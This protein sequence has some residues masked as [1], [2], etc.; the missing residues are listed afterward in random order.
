MTRSLLWTAGIVAAVGAV[1]TGAAKAAQGPYMVRERDLLCIEVMGVEEP[2]LYEVVALSDGTISLPIAGRV[3][4]VGRTLAELEADLLDR[5]GQRLRD[6]EVSVRVQMP[7]RPLVYTLGSGIYPSAVELEPGWRI[8]N[9]I[10]SAMGIRGSPDV[11]EARLPSA[12]GELPTGSPYVLAARLPGAG[13]E[14][15]RG[16]PH[17]LQA[18]LRRAGGEVLEVDLAAILSGA[19]MTGDYLLEEGDVLVVNDPAAAGV[20]VVGAVI[21]PGPVLLTGGSGAAQAVTDRG[22]VLPG[23]DLSRVL[24][25]RGDRTQI[26]V[27][28]RP[29]LVD[30]DLSKDV[31][32]GPGDVLVVP[33]G[34]RRFPGVVVS[35]EVRRPGFVPLDPNRPITVGE[36][37]VGPAGGLLSAA[38]RDE[39]VLLRREGDTSR[40]VIA[41]PDE[42]W[43]EALRAGDSLYV[44]RMDAA[45]AVIPGPDH[46]GGG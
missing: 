19:D 10:A 5:F 18:H 11:L 24:I 30:L 42:L 20:M 43:A 4:C 13:G 41:E 29:A 3:P 38:G 6:P 28:L 1:L 9:L 7:R 46:P 27:D 25:V 31:P 2:L 37:I 12:G 35:G 33:W 36:A 26:T 34:P 22:G 39:I 8:T 32:V 40:R 23:A 45:R 16:S 14:V 21:G 17:V 44:P 15:L